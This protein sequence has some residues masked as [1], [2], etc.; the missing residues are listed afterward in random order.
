[1]K[2]PELNEL[3]LEE[4]IGQIL[5]ISQYS[6]FNKKVDGKNVKR[7]MEEIKEIMGKYQF[8]S[9]W[10]QGGHHMKNVNMAEETE[11]KSITAKEYKDFVE[12]M[13]EKVRVPVI[14]GTDNESGCTIVND[15]TPVSGALA[16]GAADDEQLTFDLAQAV[17]K[18]TKATGC[19]W[20]WYPVVDIVNRYN[21]V[22]MGRTFSD[23]PD[24]IIKHAIATIKG[25]ESVGVAST[26]KHFPGADPYEIR[27]GHFSATSINISLDEWRNTQ[28][29]TFQGVID[30]GVDSVMIG[31]IAFPAVDDTNKN[32]RYLPATLSEKII[33]GLL[34]EEMGFTGVV[35]TDGIG[36]TGLQ[37]FCSYDEVIIKAINA[38]NDILLG[39]NVEDAENVRQAVLDG[40]IPMERIDESAERVLKLKEKIGLFDEGKKEEI[41]MKEQAKKTAEID[42]K[43]AEKSITLVYDRNELL[44]IS[45]DSV[46]NVTIVYSSHASSTR[47]RLG[48]MK[49]EFEKHGAKVDIIEDLP[50]NGSEVKDLAAN[51]DL[52][53]YAAYIGP[54]NPMGMPSLYGKKMET[55]FKAFSYGG[56][57]SVGV[58]MGYPYMH[59]DFM[60]AADTFFNIYA[61]GAEA[62]RAFVKVLYGEVEPTTKSPV[63]IEPK[64]RYVFG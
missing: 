12:E 18:E 20:R 35:I 61:Q 32:G 51:N 30:A 34:R 57:K 62:M 11:D 48:A 60:G 3:T 52:I 49:S 4:K 2:R 13:C 8:G 25:T 56:E 31:H 46:K 19:N 27:D 44:P 24:K 23:D 47:E 22:S 26:V 10:G 17:A 36:M 64:L 39:V 41:D 28:A 55:F 33:K 37:A 29:K 1:M 9:F 40:R 16:I 38:G 58:S 43:I 21:G 42:R 7:S 53:V 45:K 54:H 63:D 14:I 15:G 6:L 5:M 59:I 50:E